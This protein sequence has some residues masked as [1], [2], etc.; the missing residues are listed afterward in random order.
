LIQKCVAAVA[1]A[2][3]AACS[4]FA[5]LPPSNPDFQRLEEIRADLVTLGWLRPG[6]SKTS[7][8]LLVVIEGDGAAW[9]SDKKPPADPTPRSGVGARLASQLGNGWP[10]LYLARPGQYLSAEQAARCSTRYWTDQRFGNA[11]VSALAALIKRAQTPGQKV[12]LIGFSGGGVLAAELAVRRR[13]VL[14]LITVAAPLDLEA[15]TRL[16]NVSHLVTTRPAGA[17]TALLAQATFLQRHLYGGRDQVVPPVLVAP[18]ARQLPAG[19]VRLFDAMGHDDDWAPTVLAE[20]STLARG[21]GMNE[22]GTAHRPL[23]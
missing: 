5:A 10:V 17:L 2:A 7:Q 12:I 18:L 23:T 19:T 1:L 11:P 3:I 22:V 16:H 15:W 4:L 6:V 8:P 13:D 20:L 14:A 21:D 9:G